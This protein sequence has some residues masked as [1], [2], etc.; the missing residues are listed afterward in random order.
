MSGRSSPCASYVYS[1]RS[2]DY[3]PDHERPNEPWSDGVQQKQKTYMVRVR[4]QLLFPLVGILRSMWK[5]Q[6]H[7]VLVKLHDRPLVLIRY[8]YHRLN[9]H[10]GLVDYVYRTGN[11]DEPTLGELPPKKI[12]FNDVRFQVINDTRAHAKRTEERKNERIKHVFTLLEKKIFDPVTSTPIKI[13]PI[14]CPKS[15]DIFYR[16]HD[17]WFDVLARDPHQQWYPIDE[18]TRNNTDAMERVKK[19]ES[20][21]RTSRLLS[22]LT[23][24]VRDR[25]VDVIDHNHAIR[26]ILQADRRERNAIDKLYVEPTMASLLVSYLN[27]IFMSNKQQHVLNTKHAASKTKLTNAYT[28]NYCSERPFD[29][30][31]YLDMC[32]ICSTRD[33]FEIMIKLDKRSHPDLPCTCSFCSNL[34]DMANAWMFYDCVE[35]SRLRLE[36]NRRFY[37]KVVN[38]LAQYPTQRREQEET[39][40]E[41]DATLV[42]QSYKNE[43]ADRASFVSNFVNYYSFYENDEQP[44]SIKDY[45]GDMRMTISIIFIF[46][47]V[48]AELIRKIGLSGKLH[49]SIS[50]NQQSIFKSMDNTLYAIFSENSINRMLKEKNQQLLSIN[51]PYMNRGFGSLP[52]NGIN[53]VTTTIL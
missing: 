29:P 26:L 36:F 4:V 1:P 34:C 20:F 33:I 32:S 3:S 22:L 2:P 53:A 30:K 6:Y 16:D 51:A 43:F 21:K 28:K 44:V 10:D 12:N 23:T 18:E 41:G 14:D 45:T 7:P 48:N 47:V 49:N 46:G 37:T 35:A 52:N 17:W 11:S 40:Y 39:Y 9:A 15:V 31:I 8:A 42:F 5:Y 13:T 19:S 27:T 50:L 38:A 25:Y 24:I